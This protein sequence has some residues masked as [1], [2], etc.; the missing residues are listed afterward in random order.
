M[1]EWM[2]LITVS[3]QRVADYLNHVC[4]ASNM[5]ERTRNEEIKEEPS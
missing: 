2:K 1:L 4:K 5:P 3:A